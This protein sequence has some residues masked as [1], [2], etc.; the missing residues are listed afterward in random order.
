MGHNTSTKFE[1]VHSIKRQL[2]DMPF[3]LPTEYDINFLAKQT[4]LTR[5][6]ITSILNDFITSHPSGRMN[7]FDYCDLYI[8]LRKESP[9]IVEGL[10]ENIFQALGVT[11]CC[12]TD[13]ITMNE[14]LITYGN[15][16]IS[17]NRFNCLFLNL[18]TLK[19]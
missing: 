3:E 10:T 13:E 15:L 14:F 17:F 2:R 19:L 7:R 8:T 5:E 4:G 16:F 18:Y 11:K 6:Q 1:R 9:E 12:Q